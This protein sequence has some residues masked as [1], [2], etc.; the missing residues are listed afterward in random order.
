MNTPKQIWML[1]MLGWVLTAG[2]KKET[3]STGSV[4]AQTYMNVSYG[5]HPAQQ[6]DVYL[7][8]NRSNATPVIGCSTANPFPT[9][10]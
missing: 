10:G 3:E 8:S 1:A 9:N 6:L 5:N 2:C 4:E 7:P